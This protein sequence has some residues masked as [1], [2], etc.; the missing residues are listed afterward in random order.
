MFLQDIRN[1]RGDTPKLDEELQ[2]LF[3]RYFRSIVHFFLNRG[4][5]RE[6]A[7]DLTQETFLRVYRSL[8]GFRGEAGVQT[9]LFRIATNLWN[10]EVR[11]RKAEKREGWEVS[12]EGVV[13]GGHPVRAD[14]HFDGWSEPAGPLDSMLDDERRQMLRESL[15][16]LPPQMRRCVLLRI[17]QNLKYR[18]IAGVMQVSIE[19]VKSQ[20]SQARDRLERKLGSYFDPVDV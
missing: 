11:R 4:L 10:N 17:D 14:R 6:E 5:A 18:E 15:D 12:L 19:T 13:E 7:L 1:G 3:D 16:E 9:W 2:R 20:L 8:Q